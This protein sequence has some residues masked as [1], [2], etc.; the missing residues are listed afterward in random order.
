[1]AATLA[2]AGTPQVLIYTW[3][4]ALAAMPTTGGSG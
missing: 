2:V 1:M 3:T 4:E